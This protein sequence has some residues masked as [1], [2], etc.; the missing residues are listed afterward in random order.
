MSTL[1]E[2]LVQ[3]REALLERQAAVDRGEIEYPHRLAATAT[4]AGRSGV[5][6]IRIRDFQIL[7]DSGPELAGY[8]FGPGSPEIQL[9][10]LGSCL[11]HVFEIQAALAE[12]PL[13]ALSV[14]VTG[15]VDHRAG[16]P[17]FEHIPVYPHNIRY[18]VN[19]ESP[20]SEASLRELHEV[21][22]R[23]CPIFN[24]LKHPQEIQGELAYT[25]TRDEIAV[26]V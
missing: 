18:V 2:F 12:I 5:R 10:V 13:D 20:A 4:A 1:R 15:E 24:L 16:K 22:E 3:K 7:S 11:T 8:S 26:A 25:F 14:D 17:G 9:G 23:V 19:I 21:V 6:R